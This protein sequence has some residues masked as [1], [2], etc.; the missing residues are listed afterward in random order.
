MTEEI[1]NRA[2]IGQLASRERYLIRALRIEVSQPSTTFVRPHGSLSLTSTKHEGL[3][4]LF[5]LVKAP[6]PRLVNRPSPFSISGRARS[7]SDQLQHASV[8]AEATLRIRLLAIG[9]TR[10]HCVIFKRGPK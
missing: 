8:I 3:F 7:L 2:V 1:H 5:F 4:L 9:Q 10:P 6:R